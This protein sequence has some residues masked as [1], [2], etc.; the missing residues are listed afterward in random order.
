MSDYMAA[1]IRIGGKVPARL[2]PELCEQITG[3][4]VGIEMGSIPFRPESADQLLAACEDHDGVRLLCLY[5][6]QARWG[7][8]ERLEA[9]LRKHRI[10]YDRFSEGKYEYTPEAARFRPKEG[11]VLLVTDPSREPIVAA[12]GLA[13]V[14]KALARGI[15][16]LDRGKTAAGLQSLKRALRLLREK[17]PPAVPPLRAFEIE[18]VKDR[19]ENHGG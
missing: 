16:Q 3:E 9:F 19:K 15:G 11:L 18:P 13:P 6:D 1:E 7:R 14:E 5:D 2:V 4:G 10:A 17:L 8:F 12:S